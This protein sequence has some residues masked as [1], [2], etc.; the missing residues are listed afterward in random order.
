MWPAERLFW[1]C[2]KPPTRTRPP[3]A[4]VRARELEKS[5]ARS[6]A[7]LGRGTKVPFGA[8][9]GL[10]SLYYDGTGHARYPPTRLLRGA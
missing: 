3:I 2:P 7:V 1:C 9:G 8:L 5:F 6:C 4:G 10:A